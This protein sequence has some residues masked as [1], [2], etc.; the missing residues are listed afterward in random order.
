MCLYKVTATNKDIK[1]K[2]GIYYKVFFLNPETNKLIFPF[3]HGEAIKGKWITRSN[4]RYLGYTVIYRSGFHGF[5]QLKDAILYAKTIC[6]E[7]APCSTLPFPFY[8]QVVVHRCEY[9]NAHTEGQQRMWKPNQRRDAILL[10]TLVCNEIKIGEEVKRLSP[11]EKTNETTNSKRPS[12]SVQP[13]S[14]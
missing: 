7:R 5:P 13:N 11:K 2:K 9:R 10:Q 14:R 6:Y 4:D 1:R 12:G 3:V 8:T